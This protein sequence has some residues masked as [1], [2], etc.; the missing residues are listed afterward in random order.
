MNSGKK[1]AKD[2]RGMTRDQKSKKEEMEK[3][4]GKMDFAAADLPIAP[5]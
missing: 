2:K 5:E 3:D 1:L 4:W